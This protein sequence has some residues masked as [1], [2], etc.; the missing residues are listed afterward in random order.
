MGAYRFATTQLK[1]LHAAGRAADL[2]HGLI[3]ALL[4][5]HL[6]PEYAGL[7]ADF[8][9]RDSDT[10]DWFVEGPSAPIQVIRLPEDD[11]SAIRARAAEM[12]A[13]VAGL[14]D[15]IEQQGAEGRNV[16]RVL[17][18]AT[19]Y[20]PDD[21]WLYRDAPLIVNWGYS[22]EEAAV[23]GPVAIS[24]PV[25]LEPRPA[26][27]VPAPPSR[28]APPMP[29]PAANAGR[30]RAPLI[31]AGLLWLIFALTI[32]R[33]YADLLPACGLKAPFAIGD[34]PALTADDPVARE[35][36]RLQRAVEQAELAVAQEA[37]TCAPPQRAPAVPR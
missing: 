23:R 10:R 15:R 21:L 1:G 22:R 7:F 13:A 18:D 6:G 27:A 32:G 31:A 9:V 35:T 4:V 3:S 20:P 25:R 34:C 12:I 30:S 24:A 16:A 11:Q 19:V 28:P 14:A 17:R 2:Q 37:Q 26:R 8:E 33:L 5:R 29:P 36:V